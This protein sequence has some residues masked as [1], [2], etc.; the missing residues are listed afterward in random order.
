VDLDACPV[1]ETAIE[2]DFAGGRF[3]FALPV[4]AILAI[5]R[6]P[7]TPS[8]RVREYPVSI[9]Q[10]YD[11][12]SEGIGIDRDTGSPTLLPGARIFYG[13]LHNVLERALIS[14]GSGEKDGEEIKVEDKLASRM[15]ADYL[16][17]HIEA[18]AILVW[19]VMHATIKG[20]DLKKK[21]DPDLTQDPPN[22][23]DEAK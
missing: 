17:R 19:D 7:L 5:E 4:P 15:V 11:D 16:P 3:W 12:L 21:A 6:G 13:D 1:I 9:F 20:V 2:R 18:C 14:A 23:S 22:P 8:L 10:L